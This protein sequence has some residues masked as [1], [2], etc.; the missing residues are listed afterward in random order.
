MARHKRIRLVGRP[1]RSPPPYRRS[2]DPSTTPSTTVEHQG[3]PRSSRPRRRHPAGYPRRPG[4]PPRPP[5]PPPKSPNTGVPKI[6]VGGPPTTI[7]VAT[8]GQAG[9]RRPTAES[10]RGPHPRGPG[11]DADLA[12]ADR[13]RQPTTS[14]G[15]SWPWRTGPGRGQ[16]R[17]GPR[18]SRPW[19]S[20]NLAQA[21][22]VQAQAGQ[23]PGR[24][25][26]RPACGAW[27]SP[28]TWAW[29]SPI[30]PAS[31]G[32]ATGQRRPRHR[33]PCPRRRL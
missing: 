24:P 5:R 1:P 17:P 27:P 12:P 19:P 15:S 4:R 3:R 11:A 8:G 22:A 30:P 14:P 9:R 26:R 31:T 32:R 28:P 18:S 23:Q 29:A 2:G 33:A 10:R 6:P 7:A 13:H 16:P 25:G 21:Q 20:E